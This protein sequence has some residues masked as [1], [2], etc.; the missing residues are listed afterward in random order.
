ML[1][2]QKFALTYL[3]NFYR[4]SAFCSAGT[5]LYYGLFQLAMWW[6]CH[7][8]SLFWKIK[9][10]FHARSF[11]TTHRIKYVHITMVIVGLVLPALPVVVT[12][13]AAA[14][15]SRGFGLIRFPPILCSGLQSDATF[16][17]FVLPINILLAI[18]IPLLIIIFWIIHKVILCTPN[19]MNRTFGW[20]Q[21]FIFS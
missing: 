12:F 10:P 6:F 20:P 8:V 3:L 14:R 9:F 19:T 18:G 11:E 16:Y 13:A 21:Y 5:V 17:S 4:Y 7:E 1:F 15:D 2:T